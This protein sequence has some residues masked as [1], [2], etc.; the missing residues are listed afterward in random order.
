M[1]TSCCFGRARLALFAV[2]LLASPIGPAVAQ[3]AAVGTEAA[4]NGGAGETPGDTLEQ[5][6]GV[7]PVWL[8]ESFDDPFL[9]TK[10]SLRRIQISPF[11]LH[12]DNVRGFVYDVD[13]GLLHEVQP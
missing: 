3:E 7:K 13:T 6:L 10:Q 2:V 5:E 4:A 11:V 12:K 9:D 8:L 1:S